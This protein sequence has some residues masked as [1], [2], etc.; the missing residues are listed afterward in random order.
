L[1]VYGVEPFKGRDCGRVFAVVDWAAFWKLAGCG[2]LVG[3]VEAVK[4]RDG[5]IG[6]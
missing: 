6:E 5:H 3:N 4:V 2:P 1:V